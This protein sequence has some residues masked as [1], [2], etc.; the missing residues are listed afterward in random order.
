MLL[1]YTGQLPQQRQRRVSM[2]SRDPERLD[3]ELRMRMNRTCRDYRREFG[4]YPQ[5]EISLVEGWH[6]PLL[7]CSV[8]FL[9]VVVGCQYEAQLLMQL[10]RLAKHYGVESDGRWYRAP[11]LRQNGSHDPWP[12]LKEGANA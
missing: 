4:D 5:P 3:P 6:G 8:G 9:G 7:S 1:T 11:G 2:C 10:A 12:A